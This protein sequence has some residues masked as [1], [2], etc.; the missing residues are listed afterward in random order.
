MLSTSWW[1]RATKRCPRAPAVAA[2]W[3]SRA[4]GLIGPAERVG[5]AEI[6]RK[7]S[8]ALFVSGALAEAAGA[9]NTAWNGLSPGPERVGAAILAAAALVSMGEGDEALAFVDRALP[10]AIAGDRGRLLAHRASAL[11][12]LG[13]LAEAERCGHE[14]VAAAADDPT[15][16]AL[17]WRDLAHGAFLQGRLD[18]FRRQHELAVALS[19][20]IS[21]ST[22]ASILVGAIRLGVVGDLEAARGALLEA[23]RLCE[24][25]GTSAFRPLV[26][27][28]LAVV[29]W[30]DGSWDQA[31]AHA[32]ASHAEAARSGRLIGALA[33]MLPRLAIDIDRGEY[34][35]ARAALAEVLGGGNRD[36]SAYVVLCQARLEHMTGAPRAAIDRLETLL[37]QQASAGVV[38][39]SHLALDELVSAYA[40]SGS[41]AEA[42]DAADRLADLAARLNTAFVA[43]LADRARLRADGDLAAGRRAHASMREL[44]M[45]FEAAKTALAIGIAAQ[46]PDAVLDA[47]RTFEALNAEPWRRRASAALKASGHPVPRRRRGRPDSGLSDLEREIT[48]LAADGLSNREIGAVM[49]VGAR[50]VEGYLTRIYRKTHC[51]SRL[52]LAAAVAA[53]RLDLASS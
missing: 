13:R 50:T 11:L 34:A 30:L 8:R 12:Y 41:P 44:G 47:Y 31:A 26:D 52:Q 1:P 27:N 51:G 16:R 49:A 6:E 14:A 48:R 23:D 2:Q 45:P 28:G 4:L 18:D 42:R 24:E 38:S 39:G 21:P 43:A 40:D 5:R 53:G 35:R 22:R 20:T 32:D 19:A 7:R 46:D 3:Y 17:A 10:E 36:A 25:F 33:G 15:S 37:A 9:A 29:R